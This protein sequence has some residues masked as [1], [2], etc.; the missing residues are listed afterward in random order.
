MPNQVPD[1]LIRDGN[2]VRSRSNW[3]L[4]AF[5]AETLRMLEIGC[6]K[7]IRQ[8]NACRNQP[9]RLAYRVHYLGPS[10]FWTAILPYWGVKN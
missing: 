1:R 3:Q 9:P 2:F 10:V 6:G 4:A 7:P 5:R 8:V